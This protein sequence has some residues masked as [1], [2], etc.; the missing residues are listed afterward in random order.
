MKSPSRLV[1]LVT[2]LVLPTLIACSG[3][4]IGSDPER[5]SIRATANAGSRSPED[6]TPPGFARSPDIPDQTAD[7]VHVR[8]LEQGWKRDDLVRDVST[9][10]NAIERNDSA[11][12]ISSLSR[13]TRR[14]IAADSSI[15]EG[16]IWEGA[17]NTIGTIEDRQIT[18]I[19]GRNDSVAL[20]IEGKRTVDG[21][22]TTDPVEIDLLREGG[23][24]KVAYPGL[25]YPMSHQ[26][27]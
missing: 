27:R 12:F 9:F 14:M 17:R 26:R 15:T 10:L 4:K 13:R 18:L 2:L 7:S 5:D 23:K 6:S 20:R 22:V 21:V 3:E 16:R 25:H 8:T 1:V 24:W 19:G 11:V